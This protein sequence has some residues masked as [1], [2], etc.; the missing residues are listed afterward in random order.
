MRSLRRGRSPSNNQSVRRLP[1][2]RKR[3]TLCRRY[4]KQLYIHCRSSRNNKNRISTFESVKNAAKVACLRCC[5]TRGYGGVSGPFRGVG[6]CGVAMSR[7]LETL[8][9]NERKYMLNINVYTIN[10]N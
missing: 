2:Q 7:A 10:S 8:V 1:R 9:N 5:A 4:S 3:S 6:A